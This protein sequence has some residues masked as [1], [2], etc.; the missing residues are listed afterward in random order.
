MPVLGSRSGAVKVSVLMPYVPAQRGDWYTTFRDE[1]L[2]SSLCRQI[3]E[4]T[5]ILLMWR[6]GLAP[7]NASKWQVGFKSAFKGL[8]DAPK[9][10]LF[11]P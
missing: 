9:F 6:I 3:K 10:G 4:L 7:N 11:N 8:R 5:L 2:V 1:A